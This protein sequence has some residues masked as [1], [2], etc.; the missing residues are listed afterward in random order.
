MR[1]VHNHFYH[2]TVMPLNIE[3]VPVQKI[4]HVLRLGKIDEMQNEK[5]S[6]CD[7]VLRGPFLSA[8]V[9]EDVASALI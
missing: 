9:N 5:K 3:L 8:C 6:G 1:Q 4:L 7:F 2:R